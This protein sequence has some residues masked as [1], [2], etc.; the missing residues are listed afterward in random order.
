MSTRFQSTLQN[1]PDIAK[2]LLVLAVIVFISFL[3]PNNAQFN[4]KFE[5][6]QTWRYDDLIAPFDFAILKT[7]EEIEEE[8]Q[9]VD[10]NF[11]PY[12][13]VDQGISRERKRQFTQSFE[14]QL[15]V[16]R[17]DGQYMDVIENPNV[18]INFG[19]RFIDKVYDIGLIDLNEI[20]EAKPRDFVI[21][22]NRGNTTQ[23]RTLQSFMNKRKIDEWISDSL[24]NSGLREADFLIHLLGEPFTENI[25][26]SDSLTTKFKESMLNKISRTRGLVEKGSLIVPKNGIVTDN[27][28]QTLVSFKTQYNQQVTDN[29]SWMWVFIG[30]FLLTSLV[31]GV[32]L[33]F[34]RF[35]ANHIYQKFNQVIFML[36]WVVIYSYLVYAVEQV[37]TLSV[38][39]IPFCIVPIVMKIFYDERIALYT[40]IVVV[41]I[42]S[43]LSSEG[44]EFT[45]LQILA[46]IVVLLAP[47]DVRNWSKFFS[48]IVYLFSA[49]A[50]GYLGLCL[51][52]AGS[53]E[54]LDWSK[55]IW[56]FLN[57]FLTLLAYPL[58]PLIERVFG[59]TSPITLVELL[60][61]DRPLLKELSM[62]APGTLQHSLQVSNLAEAAASKI[63]ANTL[64]IKVAALYHDIGKT[65]QPKFYIENQTGENPHDKISNLESAKIIIGHVT[66]GIKLAKKHRLPT[67][68]I[69]A[70]KTHH[71]TTRVEYFYRNH[72][73]ENPNIKVEESDFVYPGPRP[74][75]KEETIL[76]IADSLEAACKSLKD[77]D[78]TAIDDLVEK[79]IAGKIANQQLED[80]KL[81]FEELEICNKEF[82]KLLKSIY[83][84]RIEYPEEK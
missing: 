11:S 66:E 70:I 57:V 54:E 35:R 21:N 81:T 45:F 36:M 12:Y 34:L 63:G 15:E 13:Q 6:G 80:S 38:F 48:S 61:M 59:F 55:Y 30:Y 44:Y 18:Y 73:K 1:L 41:L 7:D 39:M 64:L 32:F 60:D 17:T 4:Y 69:D 51:I 20:H 19:K 22:L 75:T 14:A 49:Y 52:Q 28:Y 83:H 25:S 82:K 37:E 56:I 33:L 77:P 3:F 68:L 26:F 29:K 24:F 53:L 9:K 43:F 72:I 84:V 8:L 79:I 47:I 27:I 50:L 62:K 78:E 23:R 67:I 65:V 40:H 76:M 42:A 10:T 16:V 71:G 31:I 46:G 74:R 58:I 5:P 2:V